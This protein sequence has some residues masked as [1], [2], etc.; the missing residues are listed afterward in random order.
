MDNV[1]ES[2]KYWCGIRPPRGPKKQTFVLEV[3][4]GEIIIKF[5]VSLHTV[6]T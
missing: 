5:A 6:K 2:G 4:A 3:T 1:Q